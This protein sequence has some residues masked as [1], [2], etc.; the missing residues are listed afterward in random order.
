MTTD[1]EPDSTGKRPYAARMAPELR[2][3]Q[4]LD[5]VLRVIATRGV[6]S[7]SIDAVAKEA[8]VA[9][10][11]VYKHFGDSNALLRA[12]LAREERRAV[13]QCE[14]AIPA[15]AGSLSKGDLVR[16]LYANLLDVFAASPDLWRAVFEVA[17]STTTAFRR[18][19]DRGREEAAARIEALLDA[20]AGA[21]DPPRTADTALAAR[22]LLAMIVESGRLLLGSDGV[23][24]R[25]RLVAALD[26]AVAF[27]EGV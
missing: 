6:G 11:V 19:L 5:A 25:D 17:D 14:A 27:V 1:T 21:G 15:D 20:W 16:A 8:G 26:A 3:E 9:R 22:M 12:S 7:V 13:E 2:R 4:L 24:P 10:P 18:R 23:Y